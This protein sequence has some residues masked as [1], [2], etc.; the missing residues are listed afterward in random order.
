MIDCLPF[1]IAQLYDDLF[2]V[3]QAIQ[4]CGRPVDQRLP[5][6]SNP[7]CV[8]LFTGAFATEYA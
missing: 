2:F 3:I 6:L 8:V 1:Q 5:T 4:R 7:E